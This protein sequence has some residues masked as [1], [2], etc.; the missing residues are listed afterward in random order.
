MPDTTPDTVLAYLREHGRRY[1]LR[2]LRDFLVSQ[3]YDAAVVEGGVRAY[4]EE[5][6]REGAAAS[7]RNSRA[8]L[9]WLPAV[10]LGVLAVAVLGFGACVGA[11]VQGEGAVGRGSDHRFIVIVLSIGA[12]LA[13]FGA[14][15]GVWAVQAN[16]AERRE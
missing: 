14:L 10:V 1:D 15:A 2:A 13:V 12:G 9:R 6:R 7:H 3:G 8:A 5:R 16:R 11:M 4:L